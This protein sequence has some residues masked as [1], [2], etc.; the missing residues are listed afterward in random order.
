MR[1]GL[2]LKVERVRKPR[3]RVPGDPAGR[4]AASGRPPPG[5]ARAASL[6]APWP[7]RRLG[8]APS[9]WL[10]LCGAERASGWRITPSA[11]AAPGRDRDSDGRGA[12]P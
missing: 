2:E 9:G 10:P 6:G 1:L 4:R 12:A 7:A 3:Q 11:A 8:Y 5:P